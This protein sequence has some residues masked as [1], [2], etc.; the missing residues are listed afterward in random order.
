M[1]DIGKPTVVLYK[2]IPGFIAQATHVREALYLLE[3]GVAD[4]ENID[5]AFNI[6]TWFQMGVSGALQ[7]TDYGGLDV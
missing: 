1:I 6:W 3:E 4:A 5:L 7:T 2:D